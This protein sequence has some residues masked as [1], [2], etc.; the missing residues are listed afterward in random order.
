MATAAARSQGKTEFV[1][2]VLAKNKQANA[3]AVNDAWVA[4]GHDGTISTTLVQQVRSKLGLTGNIRA[5][6][7]SSGSGKGAGSSDRSHRAG[8]PKKLGRPR[9]ENGEPAATEGVSK[10]KGRSANSTRTHVLTSLEGEIDDLIFEVKGVGG[11]HELEEALR[12][13]RRILVRSHAE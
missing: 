2:E 3:Q 7:K 12:K 11:L 13:A 9:K 10:T 6:R 8:T 4:A 5:G 1:R